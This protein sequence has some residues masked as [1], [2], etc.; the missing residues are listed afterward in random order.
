MKTPS[1]Q[2]KIVQPLD[3]DAREAALDTQQSF[4]V[5]A[6]A[7][8]GKTGLL[9]LRVLKLL[10]QAKQPEEILSIT[11]TRKAAFEMRERILGAITDAALLDA[12]Q[13]AEI[14]DPHQQKLLSYAYA[15]WQNNLARDWNLLQLPYRLRILT[16]DRFCRSLTQQM[17]LSS[18]A[19]PDT[20]ILDQTEPAYRLAVKSLLDYYRDKPWPEALTTLVNH[21]DGNLDRL[22]VLLIELLGNRDQWLPLIYGA[23]QLDQ[24]QEH[25]F[26]T[27]HELEAEDTANA[28]R[29]RLEQGVQQWAED[30]LAIVNRELKVFEGEIC[31]LLR[32]AQSNLARDL[33][34]AALLELGDILQFPK[35]SDA[36]ALIFWRAVGAIIL[37]KTGSFIKRLTKN[38]GFPPAPDKQQTAFYK[39][40]KD[41]FSEILDELR[42]IEDLEIQLVTLTNFPAPQYPEAQWKMLAALTDILPLLVA[43]L[44]L[45]FEQEKSTDFIEIAAQAKTALEAYDGPTELA[46]KLD[47]QLHHILVD[48]FQ[49]TSYAQ[50]DLL[51]LLTREWDTT[52][53][54]TLFVVG[55]GMQSCYSFR[56]AN[57]GI[58]LDVRAQGLAGKVLQPLDLNVNFR[59]TAKIIDWVNGVFDQSFPRRDNIELGAVRY[60]SSNAFKP[61]EKL[62]PEQSIQQAENNQTDARPQP[63]LEPD[64]YIKATAFVDPVDTSLEAN[65]IAEQVNELRAQYPD[66]SIA[67]LVRSRSHLDAIIPSLNAV[68]IPYSAVE[69]DRLAGRRGV[70]D[71]YALTRFLQDPSDSLA[72]LTLLRS[73]IC[74]VDN[75]ELAALNDLLDIHSDQLDEHNRKL[76]N[77]SNDGQPLNS[78]NAESFKRRKTKRNYKP[79]LWDKLQRFSQAS[80]ARHEIQRVV[81]VLSSALANRLR[82]SLVD[83]V[84]AC[85][86]SLGGPATLNDLS[87][88][89]D[90]QTFLKL[91]AKFQKRGALTDMQAFDQALQQLYAKPRE[92]H[93]NPVQ[94][95]TM[96][97]SKGLEFD[98]VFLPSL[99][100]GGASDRQRLLYWTERR[101]SQ[102]DAH[103]ILSPISAKQTPTDDPLTKLIQ[104]EGKRRAEFEQT[105]LLYVAC[106]RAKKRLFL[107]AQL[108]T[109]QKG[110]IAA[111]SSASL[112]ARIWA[113]TERQFERIEQ[114]LSASSIVNNADTD[115]EV[116]NSE[117][118]PHSEILRL[119]P[120]WP[121]AQ[122]GNPIYPDFAPP[123]FDNS[124]LNIFVDASAEH[125]GFTQRQRGTLLHRIM[126][127]MV[128]QGSNSWDTSRIERMQNFW[129]QQLLSLGLNPA[130]A[131]AELPWLSAQVE[132][133]I[134]S[135]TARWLLS[136][137]YELSLCEFPVT[138]VRSDTNNKTINNYVIDRVFLDQQTLWIIDYKSSAPID[139]E[140][141]EDFVEI[142]RTKY[143]QQMAGYKSLIEKLNYSEIPS[144]I[145]LGRWSRIACALYFPCI[146]VLAEY[147]SFK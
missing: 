23:T 110:E 35:P 85:W 5:S 57:V 75:F 77:L 140:A 9:T 136:S 111:P 90:Q 12:T 50:I 88:L 92:T 27:D 30:T 91:V 3:I 128:E 38:H 32:F 79:S 62:P 106:T 13:I 131:S 31:E 73:P 76:D 144:S 59:S 108:K 17:P 53:E 72:L 61:S 95:L 51:R 102:A 105:R 45:I 125:A 68:E 29:Y 118:L 7:G 58:F 40:Q 65:H 84:E 86:L 11:F 87:A 67:I 47:Y 37:T 109:S 83:L 48:E 100:R 14:E 24:E 133:L 112:L 21:L 46:L 99:H 97:K 1:S 19:D 120:S 130:Q 127:T 124:K 4:A 98:S 43:H 115:N 39:D 129:L 74:A 63:E 44:K 93:A 80:N 16:I 135:S 104:Q 126:Q 10:A 119:K 60:N 8:S 64:S 94:I 117:Q 145:A 134:N 25:E 143:H 103:L 78:D 146:D 41:R 70:Q 20:T 96:H 82:R 147:E 42:L 28:I 71:I 49:D 122:F 101:H 2:I 22:G 121:L 113:Q 89:D 15:A 137:Q 66:E 141:V 26:D 139:A 132:R 55:D 54:K 33:P 142:E 107:S 114:P 36:N 116:L 6:P 18:R 69:I 52:P 34:S 138:R 81:E 123:S 56:N